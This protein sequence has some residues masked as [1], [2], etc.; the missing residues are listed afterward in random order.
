[1]NH[2]S[3]GQYRDECEQSAED[4]EV[5]EPRRQPDGRRSN[6]AHSSYTSCAALP[7]D[8]V[9]VDNCESQNHQC[10]PQAQPQK[11]RIGIRRQPEPPEIPCRHQGTG[12]RVNERP[13]NCPDSEPQSQRLN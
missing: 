2:H 10:Q 3:E 9:T 12:E 6:P 7:P 4:R 13:N 1:M 5:D 11:E 8:L